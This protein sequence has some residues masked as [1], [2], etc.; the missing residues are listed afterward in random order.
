MLERILGVA[1]ASLVRGDP[2][3]SG[4][5]QDVDSSRSSRLELFQTPGQ[6]I[7]GMSEP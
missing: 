7:G 3:G 4:I 5:S 6:L 2:G 1:L